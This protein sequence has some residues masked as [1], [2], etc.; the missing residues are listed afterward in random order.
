MD[1]LEDVQPPTYPP[2]FEPPTDIDVP[3]YAWVL[4]PLAVFVAL[5]LT[6]VLFHGFFGALS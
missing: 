5:F 4:W 6:A 2:G 3:W 1:D